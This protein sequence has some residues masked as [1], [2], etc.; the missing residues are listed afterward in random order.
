MHAHALMLKSQAQAWQQ[1]L[2][3]LSAASSDPWTSAWSLD[4]AS[5]AL[6][7]LF[8]SGAIAN[9]PACELAAKVLAH[10]TASFMSAR[11]APEFWRRLQVNVSD[12][13]DRLLR[14]RS[15]I[16]SHE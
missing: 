1:V 9:Q 8:S 5:H 2:G 6:L 16:Y 15:S 14:S 4:A 11:I 3:S 7:Q 13:V 12:I 10:Q